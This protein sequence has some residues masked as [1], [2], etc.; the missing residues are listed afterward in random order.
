MY[1]STVHVSQLLSLYVRMQPRVT[2]ASTELAPAGRT[3][4]VAKLLRP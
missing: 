4:R 1:A 2:R 3:K